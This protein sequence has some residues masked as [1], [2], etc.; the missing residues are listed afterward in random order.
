MIKNTFYLADMGL[1]Y[2]PGMRVTVA[3]LMS[4]Q[5]KVDQ[6][7]IAKVRAEEILHIG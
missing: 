6:K 1:L 4:Q 7:L 2:L 5:L 3:E